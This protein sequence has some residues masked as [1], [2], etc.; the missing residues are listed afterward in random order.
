MEEVAWHG[1]EDVIDGHFR[2]VHELKSRIFLTTFIER[3]ATGL[4]GP[5][6]ISSGSGTSG[7]QKFL[8]WLVVVVAS[9]SKSWIEE[10]E[11]IPCVHRELVL[12]CPE[13]SS[14]IKESNG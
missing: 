13:D 9:A 12:S 4:K 8:S 14:P 11:C 6:W 3:A 7:E 1:G 10:Q 5:S 2:H